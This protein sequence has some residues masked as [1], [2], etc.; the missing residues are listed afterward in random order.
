M[1]IMSHLIHIIESCV[2][3]KVALLLFVIRSGIEIDSTKSIS[4][5]SYITEIIDINGTIVSRL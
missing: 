5:H 1:A 4:V 2:N 3:T